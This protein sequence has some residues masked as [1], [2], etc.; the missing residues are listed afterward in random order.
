[1]VRAR[2][3]SRAPSPVHRI[4]PV[5]RHVRPRRRPAAGPGAHPGGGGAPASLH[6]LAPPRPAWRRHRLRPRCARE[7]RARGPRHPPG[8]R[9][10][11]RD[12]ERGRR[13]DRPPAGQP[14]RERRGRAHAG[15]VHLR[16]RRAP[17]RPLAVLQVQLL[18]PD[19]PRAARRPR[20]APRR[21]AR[22]RAEGARLHRERRRDA[23]HSRSHRR[24]GSTPVR[25]SVAGALPR[26]RHASGLAPRGALRVRLPRRPGASRLGG[27]GARARP[28]HRVCATRRTLQ[29]RTLHRHARAVLRPPRRS[30]GAGRPGRGPALPGPRAGARP[31][32]C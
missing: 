23:D 3:V 2:V 26:G 14:A 7:P 20:P 18:R 16:P 30:G 31:R 8:P 4:R 10:L 12:D 24:R 9:Q 28:V 27:P 32:R 29:V 15:G 19:L 17:G 11:L 22:P 5:Q 21:R 25:R 13:P 1:M 6:G